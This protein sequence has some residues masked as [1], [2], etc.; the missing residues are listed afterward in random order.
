MMTIEVEADIA[1]F[2]MSCEITGVIGRKVPVTRTEATLPEALLEQVDPVQ[3][4]VGVPPLGSHRTKTSAEVTVENGVIIRL[5][6]VTMSVFMAVAVAGHVGPPAEPQPVSV[7]PI[8]LASTEAS[9]APSR[10]AW[11]NTLWWY[12][13][14]PPST[15]PNNSRRKI[16]KTSANSTRL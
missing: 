11:D 15:N 12:T 7:D 14:R 5:A 13:S 10:A 4:P 8:Q 1:T 2:P 9:R 16:G 6:A 3:F